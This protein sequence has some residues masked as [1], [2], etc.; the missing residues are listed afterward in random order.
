M[1]HEPG[2][3]VEETLPS[4]LSRQAKDDPNR[5]FVIDRGVPI[6]YAGI[7]DESRRVARSLEK[8]GVR[9]GDRVGIWLPNIPAWLSCFFACVRLGAIAV[10]LN[11]R[12]RSSE[13][14]E[15]I[16]RSEAKV[17]IFWPRFGDVDLQRILADVETESLA[18]LEAIVVYSE[19]EL[20]GI[21]GA[22]VDKRAY[23]YKEF[24]R[25]VSLDL[26]FGKADDGC[27]IFTT[28]GTTSGPKF[29]L[30][31]QAALLRHAS[32]V[33]SHFG[34]DAPNST[35]L[36]TLPWAGIFG[37]CQ[38][39]AAL[40]AGAAMA[41]SP[42][43]RAEESVRSF[44]SH[45]ITHIVAADTTVD[46]LL[47]AADGLQPFGSV[48]FCAYATFA[49]SLDDI[50]SRAEARGLKL[51]GVYG[52]SEVQALFARQ[53]ETTPLEE[54]VEKGGWPVSASAAVRVRDTETG[55]M[56]AHGEPGELEIKAPSLMIGY[57]GDPEA[58]ANAFTEDG[59]FRT[60]DLGY[61]EARGRFV[62]LARLDD[63]LRLGGFLVNPA[64]IE[65]VVQ[66]HPS[67][68]ECQIVGVQ[69]DGAWR[70][71]AFVIGEP[72]SRVNEAE[73]ISHCKRQL[74]G[75]KVPVRVCQIDLFPTTESAN[76]TKIQKTKLRKLAQDVLG[77]SA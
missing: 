33:A 42:I 52:S 10:P 20:G 40:T 44:S 17:L 21:P 47:A 71:F 36:L 60:G 12:F 1:A 67:V 30:H 53:W 57:F 70:A 49:P 72:G 15:V 31:S 56:L 5:T 75:S 7:D 8:L 13:I 50:G 23:D 51:V 41:T 61:T 28:S 39:T 32:D 66:E 16:R 59:Y 29:A 37:F 73:I 35:I 11:T 63:S 64:E 2:I 14:G 38:A 26:E 6:T 22:V 27:V 46:R 74:S 77:Q 45:R 54:R 4:V 65:A 24:V 48:R 34:L 58:S 43:F 18:P 62:Y 68:R 19:S 69:A 9:A 25:A 76:S 3:A 55:Q